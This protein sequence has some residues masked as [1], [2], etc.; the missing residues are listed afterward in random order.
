M[1]GVLP[2]IVASFHQH[3]CRKTTNSKTNSVY[4]SWRVNLSNLPSKQ[5]VLAPHT[6]WDTVAFRECSGDLLKIF[7]PQ[8][9]S[10]TELSNVILWGLF[11]AFSKRYAAAWLME[12]IRCVLDRLFWPSCVSGWAATVTAASLHLFPQT[13]KLVV[14]SVM[15]EWPSQKTVA[16]LFYS[17]LLHCQVS[18]SVG[19]STQSPTNRQSERSTC[20]QANIKVKRKTQ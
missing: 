4:F 19:G 8:Y 7:F 6:Q 10:K 17:L 16:F 20:G 12:A 18:V 13:S 11:L 3:C 15:F 2:W 1:L 9:C 14:L 5:S